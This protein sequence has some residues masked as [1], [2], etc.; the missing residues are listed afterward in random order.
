M[1]IL[2]TND[3]GVFS[4]GLD[5]LAAAA[6]YPILEGKS[7]RTRR[8]AADRPGGLVESAVQRHEIGRMTGRHRHVEPTE[9]PGMGAQNEIECARR[10]KIGAKRQPAIS[11]RGRADHQT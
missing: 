6:A 11:G 8:Q 1:R 7:Y 3:D 5:E 10:H 2:V 9:Q 4:P